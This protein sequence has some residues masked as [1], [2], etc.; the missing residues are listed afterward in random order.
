MLPERRLSSPDCG[1]AGRVFVTL[2]LIQV[3]FSQ[4]SLTRRPEAKQNK[5]HNLTLLLLLLLLLFLL[6]LLLL[7]LLLFLLLFLP[8]TLLRFA[9]IG[10]VLAQPTLFR[11]S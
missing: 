10:L 9:T 1:I 7:L 2:V 11:L 8:P 5:T 3:A 6:L 4:R